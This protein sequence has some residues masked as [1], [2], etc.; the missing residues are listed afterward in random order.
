MEEVAFSEFAS[1]EASLAYCENLELP[2]R[3]CLSNLHYKYSYLLPSVC[4]YSV[5]L[6]CLFSEVN[7]TF[8]YLRR[9]HNSR[10]L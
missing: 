7:A 8:I 10:Y 1:I 3:K 6:F 4:V 2:I 9:V 5:E